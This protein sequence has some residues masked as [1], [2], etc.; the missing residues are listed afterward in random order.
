M[1]SVPTRIA[2]ASRMRATSAAS[3][4]AGGCSAVHVRARERREA[5]D[6]EQVLDGVR[7]AGERR[8]RLAGLPLRVDRARLGQRALGRDGREAVERRVHARDRGERPLGHRQRRHCAAA[9]RL[10]DRQRRL[11]GGRIHGRKTG[12]G[13]TSAGSGQSTS[14][15]AI[16]ASRA[17]CATTR[18]RSSGGQRDAVLRARGV[19]VRGERV[20]GRRRRCLARHHRTRG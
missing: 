18:A 6:V 10:R 4:A 17:Y 7:D 12:A 9:D 13:S 3:A 14:G 20:A 5:G 19:D 2:P 1:L 11:R 8:Q 15:A 16:A